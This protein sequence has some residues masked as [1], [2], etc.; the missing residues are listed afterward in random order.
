V[1]PPGATDSEEEAR[2]DAGLDRL[3]LQLDLSRAQLGERGAALARELA[4]IEALRER[5]GQIQRLPGA[6]LQVGQLYRRDEMRF[7]SVLRTLALL[8]RPTAALE[9]LVK[10]IDAETTD[11][12]AML[13]QHRALTALIR[14]TRDELHER[15][16]PW[17]RIPETWQGLEIVRGDAIENYTAKLYQFVAMNFPET[18]DWRSGNER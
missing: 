11:I 8:K 17:G 13:E 2:V 9:T 15:M 4:Y 14:R 18:V 6:L 7:Q 1:Q 5:F 10:R 12:A 16:L 3:A